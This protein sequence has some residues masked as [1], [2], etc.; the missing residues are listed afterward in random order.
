M[1]DGKRAVSRHYHN[2]VFACWARAL[3]NRRYQDYDAGVRREARGGWR[4]PAAVC[5]VMPAGRQPGAGY[6]ALYSG[7]YLMKV[8]AHQYDTWTRF[9]GVITG[10][11]RG[12]TER[13]RERQ[14]R[15]WLSTAAF[16]A[17]AAGGAAGHYGVS[18]TQCQHRTEL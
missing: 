15:G 5:G 18:K 14:I 3:C 17:R 11:R 16:T 7:A 8:R 4:R 13:V 12:V 1:L 9:A 6:A 2:A 10:A